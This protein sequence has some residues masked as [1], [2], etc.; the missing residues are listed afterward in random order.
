MEECVKCGCKLL[1]ASD[2][3]IQVQEERYCEYCYEQWAEDLVED[4]ITEI[5]WSELPYETK[6]KILINLGIIKYI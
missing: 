1:P 6:E 2:H 3:I 4:L 5:D